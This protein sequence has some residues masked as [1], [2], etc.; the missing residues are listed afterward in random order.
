M[1]QNLR[2]TDVGKT[3]RGL[4]GTSTESAE[5]S[6]C[7]STLLIS[8]IDLACKCG[9]AIRFGVSRDGGAFSI[10]IYGDGE[11]YTAWC[12]PSEDIDAK[13]RDVIELFEAIW[14]DI[15]MAENSK[16]KRK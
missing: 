11:P 12:K 6:I 1:A 4:K 14:N 5:W 13:L 8:A 10:G 16:I 3:S 7:D 15:V 9:G 2:H